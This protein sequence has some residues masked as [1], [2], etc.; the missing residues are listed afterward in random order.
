M[1]GLKDT[2]ALVTGAGGGFGTGVVAA[3][4]AAG[5]HVVGVGRDAGR[6]AALRREHGAAF[7][8]E[9]GDAAEPGVAERLLAA[10][11]PATVV[12]AAGARPAMLPL[13]EQTWETFGRAWET[14][15][16][17]A[18]AWIRAALLL[19]LRAGS[20]VVAVSSGAALGG[21]PLSGG[22]A[23]AKATVRFTAAYAA[24]EAMRARL[25]VRFTALLPALTPVTGLGAEAV[26][27]YAAHEGLAVG[28][29]TARLGRVLT[30]G[31]VGAAVVALATDPDPRS[32]YRL[33]PDGLT[34][35]D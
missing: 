6:L 24:G 9:P 4:V 31:Q 21:S 28:D 13:T 1:K 15:V 30:P 33:A 34:A 10:H 32:A 8:A 17:Q 16:R 23:G 14:D 25:G 18:F 11:R 19:P 12:L 22:Y 29:F 2:T 27:A 3:L 7:T 20:T 26:A 35:L 5:A